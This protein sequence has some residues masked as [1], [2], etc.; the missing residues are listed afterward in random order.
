MSLD[1]VAPALRR[2]CRFEH[3]TAVIET[4]IAP[5]H[6]EKEFW[7]LIALFC[8]MAFDTAAHMD[9]AD[10]HRERPPRTDDD[11]LR[12]ARPRRPVA[13]PRLLLRPPAGAH[14]PGHD[15]AQETRHDDTHARAHRHRRRSAAASAARSPPTT[16]RPAAPRSSCSSAGP[17]LPSDEFEHDFKLG[18]SS[19]RVFDFV[20]GDGH[21]RARRQLRRRRQRR[22]LRHDAARAALRLR[23]AGQH[24]PADVA[25]GDHPGHARPLVRPGGRGPAGQP[26]G[27]ERG[28]LRRRPVG[29]GLR[30]RRAGRPT[31]CTVAID[32]AMCTN[33]NW[34]MAGCRFDAKRSLLLNY[35][36]AARLARRA[37][38]GRCTRCSS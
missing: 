24:R 26:A 21:E 18:S 22:V 28:H 25:G 32:T 6:P 9:T 16:W 38:S 2:R 34:M 13:V 17:W 7:I 3:R 35:L 37:R 36:P 29:R 8:F 19:T 4:L 30:S 5:E 23:A 20:A 31:R 15:T 14:P 10:A 27:L 33:C 11:G 1:R 12:Q